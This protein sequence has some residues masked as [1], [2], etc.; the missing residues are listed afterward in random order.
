VLCNFLDAEGNSVPH[1]LNSRAMCIDL[2]DLAKAGHVII[3]TGGKH[4]APAILAAMRRIGCNT[5]IT[6]EAAARRLLAL[7]DSDMRKPTRRAK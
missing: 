3:A 7:E 5:L 1:P 6:D 4:R 2:D